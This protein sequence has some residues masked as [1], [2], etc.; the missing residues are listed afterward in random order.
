MVKFDFKSARGEN[1]Y[2]SFARIGKSALPGSD[3]PSVGPSNRTRSQEQKER[4]MCHGVARLTVALIAALVPALSNAQEKWPARP[5][6]LVVP[7]AAG[8]T[9]DFVARMYAERLGRRLG[10]SVVVQNRPGAGGTIAAQSVA[11][12]APDGY[13]LLIINSQHSINT[14]LYSSLPYDTLADFAPVAMIAEAPSVLAVH[15]QLGVKTV[16]AFIELAKQR[17]GRI[18][19]GSAGVGTTT[20]LGGAAFA[21]RAGI[22]LVHVPYKGAELM[23]DL[24]SGRVEAIFVPV[25]FVLQ[26]IRDGKLVALGVTSRAS[27]QVPLSV[28]AVAQTDLP[29]FEYSTYYGFVMPAK[30][31]NAVLQQLSS[32][33]RGITEESEVRERFVSQAMFPRTLDPAEFE[34]YIRA[35]IV[36]MGPL[37]KGAGAQSN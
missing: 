15:P 35:D 4:R 34:R 31:P 32:E 1:W 19:Y 36:R 13:S 10:Q 29:G 9:I 8:T 24:L 18:N 22:E 3:N 2:A 28:P 21:A 6:Q 14:A 12:S 5:L 7:L 16:A 26:Q 33:I 23:P 30:V 20:H 37:V 27:M 17:P 11:K 25:P